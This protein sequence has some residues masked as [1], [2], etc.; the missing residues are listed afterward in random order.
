MS[1]PEPE[2]GVGGA[3]RLLALLTGRG[4]TIS[5]C[6][7]LTAGLATATFA[8]TPGA[9]SALRGGLVTYATDLKTTLAGVPAGTISRHGVISAECAAAM[10]A[11]ARKACGS[12][13]AVSL[14]GVAGPDLQEGHPVGEVW[15]GIATPTGEVESFRAFEEPER[16]RLAGLGRSAIRGA[17]VLRC[18]ELMLSRIESI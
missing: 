10:A 3:E 16:Q 6:E 8:D 5:F 4:Q 12:D 18:F 14:T 17:A 15:I 2:S 9:S 11:G 1:R 7:S 13:W